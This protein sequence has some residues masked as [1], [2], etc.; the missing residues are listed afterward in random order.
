MGWT[1]D[2]R[3]MDESSKAETGLQELGRDSDGSRRH[4]HDMQ[5]AAHA[6]LT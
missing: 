2:K 1:G 5:D 4:E 3:T 6:I